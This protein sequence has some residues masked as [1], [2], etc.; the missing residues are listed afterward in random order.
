MIGANPFVY[1]S[2]LKYLRNVIDKQG[3]C[4][5]RGNMLIIKFYFCFYEA[6]TVFCVLLQRLLMYKL[7]AL[8][9][10]LSLCNYFYY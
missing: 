5:W 2:N 7:A 3:M 10:R 6:Q 1:A 4:Y 8:K 9:E